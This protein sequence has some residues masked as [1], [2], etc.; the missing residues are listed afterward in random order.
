MMRSPELNPEGI[1]ILYKDGKELVRGTVK[2]ISKATGMTLEE[3]FHYRTPAYRY[4]EHKYKM[5]RIQ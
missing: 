2:E 3:L 1:Y 5:I 4:K